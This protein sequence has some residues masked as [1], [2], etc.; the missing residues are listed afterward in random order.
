MTLFQKMTSTSMVGTGVGGAPTVS[1]RTD[2]EHI[3]KGSSARNSMVAASMRRERAED[4][5][6][7]TVQAIGAQCSIMEAMVFWRGQ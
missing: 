3:D 2:G 4:A 6:L 5:A 1:A 7:A